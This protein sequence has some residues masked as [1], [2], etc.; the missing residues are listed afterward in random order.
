MVISSVWQWILH[1]IISLLF[2]DRKS[3]SYVAVSLVL[4]AVIAL[5]I[6]LYGLAS[7]DVDNDSVHV[8]ASMAVSN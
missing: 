2:F 8:S 1:D 6:G 4:L 7:D 5:I 3:E